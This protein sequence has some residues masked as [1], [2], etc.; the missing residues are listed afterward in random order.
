MQVHLNHYQ[1]DRV[2]LPKTTERVGR[3]MRQVRWGDY[4]YWNILDEDN[5]GVIGRDLRQVPRAAKR[6]ERRGS[7][8][9]HGPNPRVPNPMGRLPHTTDRYPLAGVG[10]YSL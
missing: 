1:H 5:I 10:R 7:V 8:G 3:P 4:R 6:Y 2:P 9:E